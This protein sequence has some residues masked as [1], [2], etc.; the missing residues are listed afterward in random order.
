MF[1]SSHGVTTPVSLLAAAESISSDG[2]GVIAQISRPA[3]ARGAALG[4]LANDAGLVFAER[5]EHDLAGGEDRAEPHRDRLERHVFF[6][7]KVAGGI[8]TRD[9]VERGDARPAVRR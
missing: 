8:A 9:R 3:R 4:R 6:A 5:D 1:P 7:E 2:V